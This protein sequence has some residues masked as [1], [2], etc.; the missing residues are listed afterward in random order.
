MYSI[1]SALKQNY[2]VNSIWV[3]TNNCWRIRGRGITTIAGKNKFENNDTLKRFQ[4][5]NRLR[6][7]NSIGN[8]KRPKHDPTTPIVITP[9]S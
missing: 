3:K 4:L 8:L 9:Q 6:G 2:M 7:T 1:D 5:S